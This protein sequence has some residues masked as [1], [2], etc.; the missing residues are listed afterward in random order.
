MNLA[1]NI[2]AILGC[3]AYP[4]YAAVV[5]KKSREYL[6][7][8]QDRLSY[9]YR[10]IITTQWALVIPLLILIPHTRFTY[11][12]L[13]LGFL[14]S[15][16]WVMVLLFSCLL[17]LVLL[18]YMK[19]PEKRL[20]SIKKQMEA[21]MYILPKN[22]TEYRWSIVLSLTAGTCE[23]VLF[24]GLM[25]EVLLPYLSNIPALLIVNVLFALGHIAT[26]LK[27]M[28]MT[29][30]L[31][32]IWSATYLYT[33]SLWV[34]ILMHVLVDLYS[35]TTAHKVFSIPD[36]SGIEPESTSLKSLTE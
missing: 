4:V 23:E 14:S 29:F 2:I 32:I 8:N 17:G 16:L 33:G 13:G 3:V 19:I 34:P 25:Y 5:S 9:T 36:D 20:P 18:Q 35:M 27:N 1:V 22:K 6:M 21:S 26:G 12:E 10:S 28:S 7:A 11:A 24:R 30:L 15:P 31:G